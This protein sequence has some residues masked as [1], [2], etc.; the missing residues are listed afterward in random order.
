MELGQEAEYWSGCTMRSQNPRGLTSYAVSERTQ[1]RAFVPGRRLTHRAFAMT[2]VFHPKVLALVTNYGLTAIQAGSANLTSAAI[3]KS[4]S[5]YELALSTLAADASSLDAQG[6]FDNWWVSLWDAS[7][8]VDRRFIRQYARLRQQVLEGNPILR[9]MI[10]TPETIKDAQHFF[11]EVGAG[12]GPPGQR[13]QVEFPKTLAEFFGEATYSRRDLR[14]RQQKQVWD[15]RPLSHKRT[16]Y[17]VDI[18]RLGMPTQTTG[19]PTIAERAIRF[20]RTEESNAFD[21]EV[22]DVGSRD[23]QTWETSANLSGTSGSHARSACSKIWLLLMGPKHRF[24]SHPT[25]TLG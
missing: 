4:P 9:T 16:S 23:F 19:G 5:N 21:F 7:R 2:P 13:H 10:E 12:S 1:I 24:R 15:E 6:K 25:A 17:G 20:T 22:T 8:V 3:G 11:L 14:L 18:W